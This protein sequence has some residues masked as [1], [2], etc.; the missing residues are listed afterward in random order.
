MRDRQATGLPGVAA[1]DRASGHDAG[2]TLD[3]RVYLVGWIRG[4]LGY[5]CLVAR[6]E[7]EPAMLA[8]LRDVNTAMFDLE[9]VETAPPDG[10]QQQK[11][12]DVSA[13]EVKGQAS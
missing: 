2:T 7:S 6:G 3:V 12:A 1:R 11:G 10:D 5:N 9:I 8:L 13:Q 4:G